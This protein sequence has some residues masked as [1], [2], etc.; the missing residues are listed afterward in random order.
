MRERRRILRPVKPC[1]G[2]I[3]MDTVIQDVE[4]CAFL[5]INALPSTKVVIKYLRY[6][7]DNLVKHDFPITP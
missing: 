1:S 2:L 6:A 7:C 5:C 4:T 3:R